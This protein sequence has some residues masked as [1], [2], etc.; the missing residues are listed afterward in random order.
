MLL[1]NR[2]QWSRKE[3]FPIN[4]AFQKLDPEKQRRIWDAVIKEFAQNGYAKASTNRM[5]QE[6]GIGKGMLFY[7]F[8]SKEDL[9]RSALEYSIDFI[10][11]AYVE[12]LDFSSPD[13]IT[14]MKQAVETKMRAYL[15]NPMPFV[16]VANLHIHQD[17]AELVPDLKKRL[18]DMAAERMA[19]FF[20]NVD[21]TL[22]RDDVPPEHV[23][24]LI[25]WSIDGWSNE[26]IASLQQV[27]LTDYDWDSSVKEFYEFLAVLRRVLYKEVDHGDSEGQ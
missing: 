23:L 3:A 17:A 26:I 6:A 22:F 1:Y 16:L 25:R 19:D 11:R 13:F 27:N 5:V 12:K 18:D 14:R 21:T 8:N 2:P 10:S 7:Y 9:F 20:A 4:D 24:N 15:E